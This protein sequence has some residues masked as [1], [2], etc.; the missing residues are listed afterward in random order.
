MQF[1]RSAVGDLSGASKSAREGLELFA[2]GQLTASFDDPSK[3]VCLGELAAVE[4]VHGGSAQRDLTLLSQAVG[5]LRELAE[6]NPEA[7]LPDLARTLMQL[8]AVHQGLGNT[9]EALQASSE[10]VSILEKL[11][12][13][14]PATF[15]SH[16][17]RGLMFLAVDQGSVGSNQ[18]WQTNSRALEILRRS[19]TGDARQL[20][21]CLNHQGSFDSATDIAM[22]IEHARESV[23]IY[24]KITP[25]D[26]ALRLELSIAL[27]NL[28]KHLSA[29]V[30]NTPDR[31]GVLADCLRYQREAE[32]LIREVEDFADPYPARI[33]GT[34]LSNMSAV[35]LS[36]DDAS[37]GVVVAEEA[38][39]IL[40]ATSDRGDLFLPILALAF[41]NLA[42]CLDASDRGDGRRSVELSTEAVALLRQLAEKYPQRFLSDL[43]F[44]IA[45]L[46]ERYA[47]TGM[48]DKISA[49]RDAVEILIGLDRVS[50]EEFG[51]DLIRE[52]SK[53]QQ[54]EKDPTLF[55]RVIE[56]DVTLGAIVAAMIAQTTGRVALVG[57]V[58]ARR[59]LANIVGLVSLEFRDHRD[60][61]SEHLL[62]RFLATVDQSSLGPLTASID[63]YAGTYS[64]FRSKLEA[65]VNSCAEVGVSPQPAVESL[66]QRVIGSE[67]V[68]IAAVPRGRR[69]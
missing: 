56:F 67:G 2:S 54:Y 33:L 38:V 23:A 19:R 24:R 25:V 13:I 18:A 11:Y 42:T 29:W 53:L 32:A 60:K 21:R 44:A 30:R 68:Q 61:R 47:R 17:A 27:V 69:R 39:D 66:F 37:S 20:A 6:A 62:E 10:S 59:S 45:A 63:R 65:A 14:S 49:Q 3:A 55:Q 5:V 4:A 58:S 8:G 41:L 12:K 46:A 64:I 31:R 15:D 35:L 48:G 51:D 7:L 26:D 9:V 34:T 50:H 52:R 57:S 43:A 1:V 36:M 40:R 22:A 28:A 16:L